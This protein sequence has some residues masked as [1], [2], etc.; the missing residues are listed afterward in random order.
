[1]NQTT[2]A[3][4]STKNRIFKFAAIVGVIALSASVAL[5]WGA[6]QHGSFSHAPKGNQ[7]A[8]YEKHRSKNSVL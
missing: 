8:A 5:G 1:M 3:F 7:M 2:G 6:A 4:C